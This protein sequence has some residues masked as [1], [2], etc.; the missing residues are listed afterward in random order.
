MCKLTV[1]TLLLVFLI[2]IYASPSKTVA[3]DGPCD[4]VCLAVYDPVCGYNGK[5]FRTFGNGCEMDRENCDKE[6]KYAEV[7]LSLCD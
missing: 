4:I 5:T 2:T 3:P 1:A 6:I 7:D